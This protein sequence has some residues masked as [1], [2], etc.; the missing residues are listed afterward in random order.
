[1]TAKHVCFSCKINDRSVDWSRAV[2]PM[3]VSVEQLSKKLS[4]AVPYYAY[5]G[6]FF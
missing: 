4:V 6:F 5:F 3:A 1:M 2:N